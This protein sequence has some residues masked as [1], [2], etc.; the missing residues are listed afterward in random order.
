MTG[1]TVVNWGKVGGVTDD[2]T[3][4]KSYDFRYTFVYIAFL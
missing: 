2:T 4:K 3:Y 1:R